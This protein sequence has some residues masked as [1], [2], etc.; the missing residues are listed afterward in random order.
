MRREAAEHV[1]RSHFD[2]LVLSFLNT[3]HSLVTRENEREEAIFAATVLSFHAHYARRNLEEGYEK[4]KKRD[5]KEDLEKIGS[6][7]WEVD[8]SRDSDIP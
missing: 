5:R 4:R 3:H 8:I 1:R 6:S 7:L 2:S